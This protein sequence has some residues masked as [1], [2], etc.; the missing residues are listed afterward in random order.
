MEEPIGF[1]MDSTLLLGR[2]EASYGGLT[3]AWSPGENQDRLLSGDVL[4]SAIMAGVW[5]RAFRSR[6]SS[7][8][9]SR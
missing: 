3:G 9:I 6:D 1:D 5:P 7:R 8:L 2:K 4:D